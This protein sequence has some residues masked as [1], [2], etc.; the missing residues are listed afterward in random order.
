MF[1]FK[2]VKELEKNLKKQLQESESH[3]VILQHKVVKNSV[4]LVY[5]FLCRLDGWKEAVIEALK[6]LKLFE[7]NE[8]QVAGFHVF[9]C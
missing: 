4:V 2:Q 9:G 7:G 8:D 3:T 1:Y 6:A 5:I